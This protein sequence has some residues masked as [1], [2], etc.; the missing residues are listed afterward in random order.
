MCA[1]PGLGSGLTL[2]PLDK[3]RNKMGDRLS[4]RLHPSGSP[5]PVHKTNRVTSTGVLCF[6]D[7]ETLPSA[8]TPVS[9]ELQ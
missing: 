9:G 3:G 5:I 8:F 6:K 7:A 2:P 4:S 1:L